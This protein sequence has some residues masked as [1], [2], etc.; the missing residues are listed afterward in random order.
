VAEL[1]AK[2][3]VPADYDLAER[4]VTLPPPRGLVPAA[5]V[6]AM[7]SIRAL[8]DQATGDGMFAL[9]AWQVIAGAGTAATQ[10]LERLAAIPSLSGIELLMLGHA[11]AASGTGEATAFE[12]AQ[13][14]RKLL[15]QPVTAQSVDANLLLA[16]TALSHGAD[17]VRT[18]L[19]KLEPEL[20]HGSDEHRAVHALIR[21]AADPEPARLDDAHAR[22]AAQGDA[23]GLAQCALVAYA[24]EA[25]A[26]GRAPL[27][28][29]YL[30]HAIFRLDSDGRPEWA[31]RLITDALV[32]LLAEHAG[33]T[34]DELADQLAHAASLAVGA[35]APIGIEAVFRRAAKLGF[36]A[37][38]TT[39]SQF[40]PPTFTRRDAAR[41][42]AP[43][44]E[45]APS[46]PKK[47]AAKRKKRTAG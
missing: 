41:A 35:K 4:P 45:P 44:A 2:W 8:E 46:K 29:G 40:D 25:A 19:D 18:L 36:E 15:K 33:A 32:P 21:A 47:P 43:P 3:Q 24:H 37:K 28:R 9:Y 34:P 22:F 12:L 6:L 13:R 5:P 38:L 27:L 16:A 11:H 1:D 10:T 17:R 7:L 30:E 20:A 23:F 31:A 14:A 39:L 26:A 42:A